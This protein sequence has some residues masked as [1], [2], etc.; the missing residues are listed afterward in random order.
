MVATTLRLTP[1]ARSPK[2]TPTAAGTPHPIPPLAVAKNPPGRVVGSHRSCWAMVD[3]DSVTS[4]ES[5]AFTGIQGDHTTPMVTGADTSV[6][7]VVGRAGTAGTHRAL[8]SSIT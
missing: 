8:R 4:G 5:A 3:V 2:A 6:S 1:R 7:M